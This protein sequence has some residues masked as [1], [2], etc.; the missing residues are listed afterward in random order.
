MT[1]LARMSANETAEECLEDGGSDDMNMG[2]VEAYISLYILPTVCVFGIFGNLLNLTILTRQKLQK[3]F[4]TLEQAANLCLISLAL[5]DFMF[6]VLAFLTMFVPADRI[7]PD[8]GLLFLYGRYAHGMINIFIMESTM[9]TV[10]MSLERFMA[11][12]YPLRQDLYLTTRRTKYIIVCTFIFSILFNIPVMFRFQPVVI[13]AFNSSIDSNDVS[14]HDNGNISAILTTSASL[15]STPSPRVSSSVRYSL[16]TVPLYNT[17]ALDTAYRIAWALVGNFIPLIL[18]IFFNV[19]LCRKIFSSYKK[20]RHLG[21]QDQP[22]SSHILTL[23]LVAIVLLFFLL[24][25]PSETVLFVMQMSDS[26]S[27]PAVEA[28][29]NLMQAI[30]FSVNFI[31]YCIISPHF[32]KMLKY[33]FV[34]GCYRIYTHS[35]DWKKE[36]ETSLM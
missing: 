29:L 28:V 22:R 34:C 33:L 1:G 15:H 27:L 26:T 14:F 31:L 30:N 21:R 6:C 2:S 5:S 9:L 13:C 19:R 12:C 4:R 16:A 24:V 36:F 18:L 23:T 8:R 35:K 17:A 10:A 11:I 32:R 20:R 3:S 7:F 25:A